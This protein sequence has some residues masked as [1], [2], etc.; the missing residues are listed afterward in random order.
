MSSV[1]ERPALYDAVSF[2]CASHLALLDPDVGT[3]VYLAEFRSG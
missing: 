3:S 1:V 2:A